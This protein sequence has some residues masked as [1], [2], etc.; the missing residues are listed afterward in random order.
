MKPSAMIIFRQ[1]SPEDAP[2]IRSLAEVVFPATYSEILSPEQLDYMMEWMYAPESIRQQMD[3]GQVYYLA[4]V[5][6]EPCGYIAVERQGEALFHLQKIYVLPS[7]QGCGAGRALFEKAVDHIR[8]LC[9]APCV[10]ELNVNRNNS[11]LQF[12]ERLGMRKVREGDFPIGNGYFM[13]DYI[14]ALDIN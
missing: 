11:A 5:D 10:M 4:Y 3:E 8:G 12:Y 9:P 13:N 6:G 2:L 7:F 14:M 1:A